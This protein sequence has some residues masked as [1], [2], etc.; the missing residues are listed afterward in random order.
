MLEF[1]SRVKIILNNIKAAYSNM[2]AAA[3]FL[4]YKAL[5]SGS[6]DAFSLFAF[7]AFFPQ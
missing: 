2:H 1:N 5:A 6:L 4:F 7:S 3:L